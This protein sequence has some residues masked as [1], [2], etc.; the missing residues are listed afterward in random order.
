MRS[1][2]RNLLMDI[3]RIPYLEAKI[4]QIS[5]PNITRIIWMN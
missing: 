4:E 1:Y 2:N 3:T 5:E